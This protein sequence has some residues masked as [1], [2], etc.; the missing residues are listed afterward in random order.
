MSKRLKLMAGASALLLTELV[1]GVAI[2]QSGGS[3]QQLIEEVVITSRKR[4]ERLIDVPAAVT[5][6]GEEAIE[7][8]NIQSVDELASF[9]PGL[10]VAES[11][12]SSGG[13]ISLRGIGNGSTNYLG[14]QAVAI[15]VDGMQVGSFNVRKSAQID[16]AQIEVLRGPQS[17]FFGKNSPGGVLSFITADPTDRTEVGISTEYEAESGDVYYQALV[18]GQISE[19]VNARLVGRFTDM[20]GYFNIRTVPSNG[21]SLIVPGHVKSWP[22]GEETFV[23]GTILAY[24][25]DKLDIR[26]KLTYSKSKIEGGSATVGQRID[27]PSGIAQGGQPYFPCVANRDVYTGGAPESIMKLIPGTRSLNGLGFRDNRQILATLE[28]NYALT[29]GVQL[30]SVTGLFDFDEFNAH[31]ATGAPS[32]RVMVPFL[33][34]EQ[35]Q[36]TQEFRV[37]SDWSS[38][39]NFMSGVFFE[40][41]DT[42]ASQDAVISFTEATAFQIGTETMMEEQSAFSA[43]AEIR[44]AI[45][46]NFDLSGGLRY[47]TED[48]DLNVFRNSIDLTSNLTA[49]SVSFSNVSREITG[50]YSPSDSS[51]LFASYKEGFKSGGFDGGFSGGGVSVPGYDNHYGEELVDGFE[52]GY[53]TNINNRLALNITAYNY[54]YDDLQVGAYD[55]ATISFKIRNAAEATVRGIES[56][57]NWITPV[58]G[59]SL[60]G[61]LAY[62]QAK[63][64]EFSTGC[65]VGQSPA[66]GCNMTPNPTT[67]AFQEQDLSGTTMHGAP[68]VVATTG[69]QYL[70]TFSNGF[71]FDAYLGAT[72]SDEYT[73]NLRRSPQDYQESFVKVNSTLK[74]TS[75]TESWDVALVV[76]NMTDKVTLNTTGGVT[77][78]GGGT[79]TNSAFLGDRSGWVSYGLEIFLKLNYRFA[80]DF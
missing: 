19:K 10:I 31:N 50:S 45:T 12:V 15:N 79:G 17:L 41:K 57:I 44:W 76:R 24:P 11:S 62:N 74:V 36:L 49:D 38:P 61:S 29:D 2:A 8:L 14:D 73:T 16:L 47:T 65:Y 60:Q 28:A 55:P 51:L 80:Q 18:S 21:D 26:A 3:Q 66:N 4:E 37:S 64:D 40:G 23:R 39:V 9:T 22:S 42:E 43:F 1:P 48:K 20:N 54:Q 25:T 59:I 6:F 72:Y 77:L 27:C 63:F 53:K 69:L 33:P 46:D 35:K 13:S 7:K 70:K 58:E 56:D 78:T 34:F 32:A 68:E 75:P 52:A 67:G 5:A 71:G 30:T